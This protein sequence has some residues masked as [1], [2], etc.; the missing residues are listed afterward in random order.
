M[1]INILKK[2]LS[3]YLVNE[4]NIFNKLNHNTDKFFL[5][6]ED[7]IANSDICTD[8]LLQLFY[9]NRFY[10]LIYQEQLKNKS[11]TST[12]LNQDKVFI[13]KIEDL[14]INKIFSE[15]KKGK[16]LKFDYFEN[17]G[18]FRKSFLL[19]FHN[20]YLINFK[21]IP[22]QQHIEF[23]KIFM[24]QN[25]DTNWETNCKEIFNILDAKKV[26]NKKEFF[27]LF[28]FSKKFSIEFDMNRNPKRDNY[29]IEKT[30][31]QINIKKYLEILNIDYLEEYQEDGFSYDYFLPKFNKIL[32]FDGPCH[33]YP[34][35]T[36]FKD[37]HKF[38]YRMVDQAFKRK[39]VY[40][41]YFE[42]M[43]LEIESFSIEYLK[44]LIFLKWDIFDTNCFRESYDSNNILRKF[45]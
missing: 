6:Y 44:K 7:Q 1:N 22:L 17:F 2:T 38:R 21:H 32:E 37:S 27:L 30:K 5:F 41:P 45:V 23:M 20:N 40:V 31:T 13:Y 25:L 4:I 14:Y 19:K 39:I 26:L 15:I 33:F 11:I 10:S 3:I 9:F 35:Q 42:W 8:N 29:D 28:N 34:L 12:P 43:K 36:Q 24:I 16:F 18:N